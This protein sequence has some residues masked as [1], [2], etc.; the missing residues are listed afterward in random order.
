MKTSKGSLIGELTGGLGNQL[1]VLAATLGL[2]DK[3][4]MNPHY[5]LRNYGDDSPRRFE[6]SDICT[7]LDI[8]QQEKFNYIFQESQ[9]YEFEP[10]LLNSKP[11]TLIRGYFQ[12]RKYFS[13]METE[14][15]EL[16]LRS[17]GVSSKLG[18]LDK[19]VV[20][21]RRGDYLLPEIADFHGI[22]SFRYYKDAVRTLRAIWG[23]LPVIIFSDSPDEAILLSKEIP[24]SAYFSDS[25][26]S[27]A[28]VLIELAT[29]RHMVGSNSSFSWWAAFM[30]NHE[31]GNVIF[32]KPWISGNDADGLMFDNWIRLPLEGM[33]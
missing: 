26:M 10:S 15:R 6:I 12:N 3:L 25:G 7:E 16:L 28:Q 13:H 29:Y 17:W 11:N 32:P 24:N 2:A 1:F 19:I 9:L 23:P 33:N 21:Q 4:G 22:A 8:T 27:S 14:I 5:S 31:Y 18:S 30:A 20:H